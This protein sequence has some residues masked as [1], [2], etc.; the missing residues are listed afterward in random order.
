[1]TK[2]IQ[3]RSLIPV[4]IKNERNAPNA[5]LMESVEL[6]LLKINS[7]I[8]APINGHNNC[9]IGHGTKMPIMSPAMAPLFPALLPPNFLVM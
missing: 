2:T 8:N 6:R 7:L 3:T 1:M 9:P 5:D 4:P